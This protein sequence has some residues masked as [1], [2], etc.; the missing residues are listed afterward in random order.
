MNP[1]IYLLVKVKIEKI[2]EDGFICPIDYSS[3]VSN[4]VI[5]A[6]LDNHISARV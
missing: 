5:V 1:K 6:E 3:W 4:I 2:L